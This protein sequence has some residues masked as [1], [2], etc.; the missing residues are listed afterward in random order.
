[1]AGGE[2]RDVRCPGEAWCK[3]PVVVQRAGA[4]CPENRAVD[5]T[6]S[7]RGAGAVSPSPLAGITGCITWLF[8]L[9][10]CFSCVQEGKERR[11]VAPA[12][13]MGR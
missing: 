3:G 5:P 11:R 12:S 7:T 1:M 13:Q 4:R 8:L 9:P 6:G 2:D 10:S